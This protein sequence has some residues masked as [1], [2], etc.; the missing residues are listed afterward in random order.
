MKQFIKYLENNK[1]EFKSFRNNSKEIII[2]RNSVNFDLIELSK[3]NNLK[4]F[5]M[6]NIFIFY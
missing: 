5:D 2:Q 3:E 1:I 6:D 4:M